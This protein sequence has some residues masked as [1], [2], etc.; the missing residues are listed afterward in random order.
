VQNAQFVV[1]VLLGEVWARHTTLGCATHTSHLRSGS[2][3]RRWRWRR[4]FQ[5]RAPSLRN[6]TPIRRPLDG[7]VRVDKQ[8]RGPNVASEIDIPNN[9]IVGVI[10]VER[11]EAQDPALVHVQNAQFVVAVLL[12]EVWAR[13]TTLGCATHT[14][15]LRS[16][17][18]HRRWRWRRRFQTSAPSLRNTIFIR[19]PHNGCVRV[20]KQRSVPNVA[21]ELEITNSQMVGGIRVE[22][23]EAQ[24]PA[25]VHVQNAQFVVAVP[26]GEVWA[27]HTTLGCA[28]H[29]SPLL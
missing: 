4:R 3:H 2:P 7:C 18:P 19:R 9:Q 23:L 24:D 16:G 26:V 5:T 22:R 27:R 10:R 15:H 12:G 6:T 1:A 29:T 20:D 17:S 28:T 21:T 11:L 25:F 8:R 14:S 13:H